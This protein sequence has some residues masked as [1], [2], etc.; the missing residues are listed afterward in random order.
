MNSKPSL[1]RRTFLAATGAAAG[2]LV[3]SS[4]R[5]TNA[6]QADAPPKSTA[7]AKN[8]RPQSGPMMKLA[9]IFGPPESRLWRLVKQCGA[10]HVVGTFSRIGEAGG[11]PNE[12]PWSFNS[13]ARLKKAY[14][15]AGFEFAVLESRPPTDK[16]KLALP[17][18]DEQIKE[19]CELIRNMGQLHIPVWCY[20]W[21]PINN[22][23]R[24]ASEIRGRGGAL[25]TGFDLTQLKAEPVTQYGKVTEEN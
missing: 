1:T 24:T 18:R 25:V 6:A 9:E 12:K 7:A 13:L 3:G 10:D 16:I 20:E 19:V 21:M 22:W 17:G 5:D 15:D 2:G 4:F 14:E 11:V 23:T 8:D